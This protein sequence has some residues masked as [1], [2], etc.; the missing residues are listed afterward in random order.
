MKTKNS[1]KKMVGSASK[2]VIAVV[3]W[4]FLG[5]RSLDFFQFATPADQWYM[6]WLAFGLTGG[7][8]VAYLFVLM[9]DAKTQLQT[10]IAILMLFVSLIGEVVSAGFGFQVDIW[11]KQGLSLSPDTIKAMILFVQ[12]LALLHGLAL[13]GYVAGD[14]IAE[15][16]GDADSDGIP[17]MLDRDYRRLNNMSAAKFSAPTDN[18]GSGRREN[19]PL[20]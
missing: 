7:G 20:P 19:L 3:V 11:A 6:A 1:L 8:L 18:E 10:G 16:F 15:A 2:F 17:N 13:V 4:A 14:K 12:V 5:L 9:Y